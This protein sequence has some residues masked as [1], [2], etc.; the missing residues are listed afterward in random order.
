MD[1]LPLQDLFSQ[2][3]KAGLPLG[4]DDYQLLL[5]SLQAGFGIEDRSSLRKLCHVLWAKSLE[6]RRLIDYHFD[7]MMSLGS[8]KKDELKS[9]KKVPSR[10]RL[11]KGVIASL[12]LAAGIA[13]IVLINRTEQTRI[14]SSITNPSQSQVPP[15]STSPDELIPLNE[16]KVTVWR[17]LL[18][19]GTIVTLV[20]ITAVLL[21]GLMLP[22]QL[23]L[24]AR[25]LSS[26]SRFKAI[27]RVTQKDE[28]SPQVKPS[29]G[30]ALKD[31]FLLRSDYLPITQRQ[32]K[33][34]WRYLSRPVREGILTE[35]DMEATVRNISR[36]GFFLNPVFLPSR[37]NRASLLILTDYSGSM[38]PFKALS[39]RIITTARRGGQLGSLGVYYFQ[40]CPV[41]NWDCPGDYLLYK[42]KSD[43]D[44]AQRISR[45]LSKFN[46]P[47]LGVLIFS[48]AGAARGGVNER[49]IKMTQSFLSFLCVKARNVV[50]VNPLPRSRWLGT[51]AESISDQV[52]MTGV[53]RV[54][55]DIAISVLRGKN[56]KA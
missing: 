43:P 26:T 54:E 27:Q 10:I 2:L 42:D 5:S 47:Q 48:D 16:A 46:S 37:T 14:P 28:P 11:P 17:L 56:R 55:I 8:E 50:W 9:E 21:F 20:G 18:V 49:R 33:R 6:E 25:K 44:S 7:Q 3:Q 52:T 24:S 38:V 36:Q 30:M 32:M 23:R 53:D 40:N 51:T 39:E 12:L 45:I 1:E 34:N 4:L 29:S 35:L 19:Y 13:W 31:S 41:S 22:K 15:P